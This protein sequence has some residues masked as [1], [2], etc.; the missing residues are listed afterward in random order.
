VLKVVCAET[1]RLVNPA[2]ALRLKKDEFISVIVDDLKPGMYVIVDLAWHK[3]PFL[4]NNFLITSEADIKK[5]KALGLKNCKIDPSRSR[6]QETVATEKESSHNGPEAKKG[7]GL[8]VPEELIKAVRDDVMS[9]RDK[10]VLVQ[11]HSFTMMKNLLDNPSIEN[12]GQAKEGIYRVVDLILKDEATLF[13]LMNITEHDYCTYT[14]SVDVGILGVAL[15]KLLFKDSGRHDLHALG[16]GFFLHDIGKVDI[17]IHIINKP[18][19]LTHEEMQEMKRHPASGYKLLLETNQSTDESK[20][21]VL[22]HHEKMDGT[23]YPQRLAGEQIHI[24]GRICAI[25]DV[26]NALT[27]DRPYKPRMQAFDALKLMREQMIH[28]F[29]KDLFERFVLLISAASSS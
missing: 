26:Y 21:I 18:G 10:A 15:A 19:K 25:V 12:I 9:P 5:I 24:Y 2:G 28:H 6:Q 3:H 16:A 7:A 4:K 27:T 17:D 13:Y 23:G 29:Q 14:H 20:I 8:I 11:R 22:Q 1:W